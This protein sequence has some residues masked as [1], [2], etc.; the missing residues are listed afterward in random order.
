MT[1]KVGDKFKITK[2]NFC[3]DAH[4]EGGIVTFVRNGPRH[5][6]GEFLTIDDLKLHFAYEGNEHYPCRVVPYAHV[7]TP[8][9]P[10]EYLKSSH[11]DGDLIAPATMLRECYGITKTERVVVEWY[12]ATK[13]EP[14]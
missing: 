7:P 3:G 5:G 1:P 13:R 11:A 12:E 4:T 9:D 10:I 8:K 6:L 2:S 14:V